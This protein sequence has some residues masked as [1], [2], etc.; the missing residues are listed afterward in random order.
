MSHD[1]RGPSLG[2]CM[3]RIVTIGGGVDRAR[4]HA[5]FAG[6]DIGEAA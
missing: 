5:R 6:A 1:S 2:D 4:V 3:D